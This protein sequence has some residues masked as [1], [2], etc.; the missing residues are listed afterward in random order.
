M[1]NFVSV[2]ISLHVVKTIRNIFSYLLLL[3]FLVPATGFYYTKHS[4]LKSGEVQLILDGEYSCSA[5]TAQITHDPVSSEGYCC[6]HDKIDAESS[7]CDVKS[8][9]QDVD[10]EYIRDGTSPGCC[11]N[12]GNYLKSEDEYT[13]P[14]RV[15]MP[16]IEIII[17]AALYSTDL[18]QYVQMSIEENA[19]SP[20]FTLSSVDILHKHSVLII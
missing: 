9:N 8:T 15:E 16:H 19:H 10:K 6:A 5:E 13:F 14:G 7:I 4:C 3:M 18:F 12:E 17:T 1:L 11:I 2:L 20:P